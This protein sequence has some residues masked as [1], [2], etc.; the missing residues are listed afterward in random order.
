[1]AATIIVLLMIVGFYY[2]K[3]EKDAMH[4]KWFIR[5][6]RLFFLLALTILPVIA[7]NFLFPEAAPFALDKLKHKQKKAH[8]YKYSEPAYKSLLIS[9]PDDYELRIE[10]VDQFYDR[11]PECIE[12]LYTKWLSNNS[13]VNEY[14]HLYAY[15][16]S[17]DLS[18]S[19]LQFI[20]DHAKTK[21]YYS[22][23]E[24]AYY[25]S[26]GQLQNAKNSW[27]KEL[28]TTPEFITGYYK[29][30]DLVY[31]YFP[32]EH[33]KLIHSSSFKS[34]LDYHL[35]RYYYWNY[36]NWGDYMFSIL[37][38]GFWDTTWLA[39]FAALAISSIW[40]IFLRNM[41]IYNKESWK[42]VII[43]FIAGALFTNLCLP[44]YDYFQYNTSIALGISPF[45]DFIYS[46]FVIGFSEELVK[47]IPLI[48]LI[49]FTNKLQEPFDY[50]LYA[51]VAAL[52]FAFTE[53][54]IYLQEPGNI[55]IRSVMST[56]GH[57]F[58]SSTIAYTYVLAKYKY[59][60]KRNLIL[61][62]L[63]GFLLACFA[64]GFYDFWLLS[65][66][67][68]YQIITTLFMILSMQLWFY[69]KSN[70]ISNSKFYNGTKFDGESQLN[71][72]IFGIIG[73]LMLEYTMFGYNYGA[74]EANYIVVKNS[75]VVMFFLIYMMFILLNFK[76]VPGKWKKY[77]L[78]FTKYFNGF[79]DLTSTFGLSSSSR[80][81]SE[82]HS[83]LQ[84]MLYAPKS[85]RYISALF[86][87]SGHCIQKI[88]VSG[89]DRWYLFKF[90]KPLNYGGHNNE[91]C[92]I[93]VHDSSDSLIDDKV[94]VI[95]LF[96]PIGVY[97]T[98]PNLS[99]KDLTYT[100][101]LFAREQ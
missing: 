93:R 29:L 35:L 41:D 94:E 3:S 18:Q 10:Y 71:L 86:P 39:I 32:N 4:N 66:D 76:V 26:L 55:V 46:V 54:L 64:H 20:T 72:L 5:H 68:E 8:N 23:L 89:D 83:G 90:N 9:Y 33:E 30:D 7:V 13:E 63:V 87:K 100:G 40:L 73:V 95:V 28:E 77:Q 61:F 53:N 75:R 31:N 51:S 25:K 65:L 11:Y 2:R 99:T 60:S 34:N 62:P 12:E 21:S 91:H 78:N 45:M 84:L 69:Y 98:K 96:F 44:I 52:G 50:I 85:N 58:W 80:G 48:L 81:M 43:V 16:K 70:A 57:M 59:K 97:A 56:V 74:N 37:I 101:N 67:G 22:F 49:R 88:T 6:R 1:M 42:D 82:D 19:Q 14:G 79:R 92:V 38:D 27:S 47:I 36:G 24:G 17:G 15:I